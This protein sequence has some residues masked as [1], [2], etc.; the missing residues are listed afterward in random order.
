M[1]AILRDFEDIK[2]QKFNDE[3]EITVTSEDQVCYS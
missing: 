1:A 3:N 2:T